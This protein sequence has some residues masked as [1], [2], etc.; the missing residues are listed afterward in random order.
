MGEC[1]VAVSKERCIV[2]VLLEGF[3]VDVFFLV[4]GALVVLFVG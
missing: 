2:V 1:R 3:I 4:G